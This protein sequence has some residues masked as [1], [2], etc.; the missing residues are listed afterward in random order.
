MGQIAVSAWAIHTSEGI[1]VTACLRYLDIQA[2]C[3]HYV[4]AREGRK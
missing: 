3:A 1:L 2:D 4:L